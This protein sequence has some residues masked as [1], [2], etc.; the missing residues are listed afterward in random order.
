MASVILGWTVMG[1]MENIKISIKGQ[2]N[3]QWTVMGLVENIK[4]L[5]ATNMIWDGL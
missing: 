4:I 3:M 2:Y 1:V 5:L